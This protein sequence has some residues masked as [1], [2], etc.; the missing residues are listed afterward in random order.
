MKK[1]T[2]LVLCI[3]IISI[4]TNS[5]AQYTQ[6]VCIDPGHGGPGGWKYGSNG[7][8]EG[9]SGPNGLN[10]EWVNLQVSLKLKD[11]ILWW[12]GGLPV[13]TMTRMEDTVYRPLYVRAEIANF[14][15]GPRPWN[16]DDGVYDFVCIHHNGLG[17]DLQGTETFWCDAMLSDSGWFREYDY[18]VA[19]KTYLRLTDVFTYPPYTPRGCKK[20]CYK[21]LRLT[22]MSSVYSEATNIGTAAEEAL[23]ANE[24]S[25]HADTEAVAIYDGWLSH[26]LH[27][28]IAVIR[29]AYSTGSN[30]GIGGLVGV[31][32]DFYPWDFDTVASPHERCWLVGEPHHLLAITP[33]QIGSYWYTFHHWAHLTSWGDQIETYDN[34][35]WH[36]M[37]PGDLDDYH[38]YVA[39]FTGGPYSAQVVSPNGWEIWHVGEERII[40]WSVSPGADSTTYVDVF[41]DRNGGNSGYPE[42]LLDSI[43][44]AYYY[45][46]GWTVTGPVS[47]HCRIKVV[48]YDRAGNSA[49]DVSNLDFSISASGNNNPEIKQ[50]LHC[51][52]PYTE[53]NDCI[54]WGDSF[55]L[56]VHAHDLDGDSM[57]YEWYCIQGHFPNGQHTM[58]TPQ[59]YVVY[60]APT[61][62][63][64]DGK[65]QFQDFL[66]CTAIDVRG[67]SND[68]SGYLG[69]YDPLDTCLCGDVD[70]D[71]E[72]IASDVVFLQ[73]YFYIHGP[74]FAPTEIGD[75]NND[76]V[77]DAADIVYLQN[78]LYIHGPTTAGMLLDSL[79]VGL[80]IDISYPSG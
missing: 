43:P 21:V 80:I 77:V 57:Y 20:T 65:N 48:A 40:T 76:C 5:F 22:T 79:L 54:K 9:A 28:G 61:K 46:W 16:S 13:V 69:I 51:K 60:T 47:T 64:E 75:V 66:N 10:E 8:G 17:P 2:L 67:G 45:G 39:Y 72:L 56:E 62:A 6:V 4:V 52:Y 3:I 31:G 73:N 32:D 63:E 59:N 41:L 27:G 68:T 15:N 11:K 37:V 58:T 25:G 33:Q 24:Y 71:S 35:D 78:Y 74:S 70:G 53:C 34:A 44:G 42:K 38:R 18:L 29:N 12:W 26:N 55:T 1:K 19:Y 50:G 49:W 14:A 30:C 36:M 7:D 23:F